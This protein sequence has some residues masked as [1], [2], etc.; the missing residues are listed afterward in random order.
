MLRRG[1]IVGAGARSLRPDVPDLILRIGRDRIVREFLHHGLVGG[2]GG[3][4]VAFF[5]AGAA[6]IELRP[7]RVFAV[8]RGPDDQAE[9]L[10][11]LGGAGLD[12]D[13]QELGFLAV[14]I[15]FA[16]AKHRFDGF[17]EALALL[18]SLSEDRIA[19][20]GQKV[21]AHLLL[22]LAQPETRSRG[23]RVFRMFLHNGAVS[24]D[25]AAE[26][27]P[28]LGFLRLFEKLRGGAAHFFVAGGKIF[29]F[30]AR[31]KNDGGGER[32]GQNQANHDR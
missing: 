9:N 16:D 12:G 30:F 23:Q 14:Q 28:A 2:D 24:L 6:E 7:R 17:L 4:V 19:F 5:F 8:G 13:A 1:G 10:P 18:V 21:L 22:Q 3:L 11:R 15:H 26:I 32:P 25:R 27:A 29:R 31:L 20:R